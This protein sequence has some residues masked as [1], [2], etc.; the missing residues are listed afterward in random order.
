MK[1][2]NLLKVLPI[3]FGIYCA[4]IIA[5]NVLATK[6]IDLL[7]FTVTT[8]IL[9]SPVVFIIQDIS[10]ELFGYK[11]TKEMVL[12]SFSLNILVVLLF[13][14]A[15]LL[16]GSATYTGQEHFSA[17]LEST[18]RISLSSF[19]AYLVGSLI[20]SKIMVTL[21]EK[22]KGNLFVRAI[23]STLAGQFLDNAI[24]SFGAFLFVLPLPA[25]LSMVVGGT[26]VE[27]VYEIILYPLTKRAIAFVDRK[28]KEGDL[29]GEQEC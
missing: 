23:S 14:L 3:I 22:N 10:C 20:N 7:V 17:V 18:L 5:Q 8:G 26:L 11:K 27:V 16:P 28:L 21:R 4:A 13:Q 6:T 29:S 24:F 1:S 12:L 25:I 15:I 9:V 19:A 2:K